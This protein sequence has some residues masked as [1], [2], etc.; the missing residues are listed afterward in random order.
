[1]TEPVYQ[2][3]RRRRM[4]GEERYRQLLDI[5]TKVFADLGYSRVGTADI[6]RAAG[7][8]EPT[9]YRHFPSK[10]DLFLT[11]VRRAWEQIFD[12]WQEVAQQASDPLAALRGIS[13]RLVA[14]LKENPEPAILHFRS[15]HEADDPEVRR[16]AQDLYR[17]GYG[18]VLDLYRQAQGRGQLA[19]G[20]EPEALAGLF[21]GL[22]FLYIVAQMLDL[23]DL[24]PP[25]RQEAMLRAALGGK[26]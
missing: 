17:Q 9:I 21:M 1:M 19:A 6:A 26:P 18:F 8:A 5:A 23:W 4:P 16:M 22:V 11:A 13:Q 12:E 2:P 7:V 15:V 14:H 25:Q 24:F 10:R 20:A 3:R